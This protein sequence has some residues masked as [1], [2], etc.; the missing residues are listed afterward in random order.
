LR[1]SVR[2]AGGAVAP[3]QPYMGMAAHAAVLRDDGSVFIHLHPMGTVSAASQ[4]VFM[5][6]DRGDTTPRGRLAGDLSDPMPMGAMRMSGALDFPYEFPKAGRYR[7]WV[8]V[9]PGAHVLTG[10]FDV[11]IR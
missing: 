5:L 7:V 10:V 9:K 1:F 3:L 8:E 6:R 2:D 4:R 11:M